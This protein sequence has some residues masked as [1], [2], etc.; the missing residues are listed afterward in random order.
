MPTKKV[1]HARIDTHIF[2]DFSTPDCTKIAAPAHT[3]TLTV[4]LVK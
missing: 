4:N 2:Q 1:F 3:R